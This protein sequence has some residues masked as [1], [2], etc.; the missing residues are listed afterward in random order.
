MIASHPQAAAAFEPLSESDKN[1][2]RA[3]LNAWSDV[4]GVTFLETT[5]HEGDL[6]FAFYDLSTTWSAFRPAGQA[7]YPFPTTYASNGVHVVPNDSISGG[8]VWFDTDY[9]RKPYFK[10]V[11]FGTALHEI[12]HALGLKHPFDTHDG[13]SEVLTS[14]M[15][16][17]ANTVMSYTGKLTGLG[18][19]DV[20]AAQF[21][22]GSPASKGSQFSFWSFD[23][24][25]EKFT[26]YGT[27]A[28]EA[29]RGT[30]ADDVIYSM[31]GSDLIATTLGDDAIYALGQSL[32]VNAG[33]GTDIVYTGLA[34]SGAGALRPY[35][36]GHILSAAGANQIFF[37][38]EYLGFTNG[39][40]AVGSS[41][42]AQTATV[43]AATEAYA[44]I[45]RIEAPVLH[46]EQAAIDIA[47][48][49]TTLLNYAKSL[50]VAAA[51]DTTVP[52]LIVCKA[53][54]NSALADA[55]LTSLAGFV[56]NQ[57]FSPNYQ[58]TANPRLGGYEA[59]G[60]ALSGLS[61]ALAAKSAESDQSFVLSMY[62]A[63]FGR[64]ASGTQAGH[65][66]GQLSYFEN[67]YLGVGIA[68]PDAELR[69]RGA[70]YGQMLGYAAHE[71]GNPH[72]VGAEATLLG[73]LPVAAAQSEFL[74]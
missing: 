31:G 11:F 48:G 40:Y 2:V 33:E 62:Q 30:G 35:G 54:L 68:A 60:L 43:N 51:Q 15:D 8:D 58:A 25:K 4:C 12:G 45:V 63:A 50:I 70:V 59:I 22:Y 44:K 61:E 46:S 18:P 16:N 49:A 42:F 57:I 17:A 69:A 3:A 14:S 27:A 67:L 72:R 13:H 23:A 74:V 73:F 10:D 71:A 1:V 41:V 55:Q 9:R 56:H 32:E 29:L 64:A 37:G 6:T 26:A 28:S 24:G 5:R 7:N 47:A 19:L 21:I 38:V 36:S 52:A 53:M 65:F 39:V 20:A 66:L 34:F